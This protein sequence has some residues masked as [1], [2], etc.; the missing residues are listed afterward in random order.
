M[1]AT[2]AM[3]ADAARVESGKLYVHGGGWDRIMALNFPTTHAS[4]AVALVFRIEYDE[5]LEDIPITITL[6]TEDGVAIGPRVEGAINA[7]H[8]PGTAR[9]APTFHPLAIT[10]TALQFD[11]PGRYQ[12]RATSNGD[13]LATIPF[14]LQQAQ[15]P[16]SS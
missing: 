15:R 13:T 4:L 6:E 7:G 16:P 8:P 2:T 3:L 11:A 14:T 1:Q 12:F 10:L 9:G 5:A